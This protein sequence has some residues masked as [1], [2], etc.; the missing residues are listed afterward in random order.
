[1]HTGALASLALVLLGVTLLLN[2]A[3]RMLVALSTRGPK[4]A[5]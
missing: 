2:A 3:A 4:G 1:V 5:L